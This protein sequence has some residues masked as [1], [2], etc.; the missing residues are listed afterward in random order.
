VC[1]KKN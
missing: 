1:A